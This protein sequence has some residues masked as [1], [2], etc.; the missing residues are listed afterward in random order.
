M[1]TFSRTDMSLLGQ[2]WQ[3]VDRWTIA[4][5]ITLATLGAF[6]IIAA[7]PPIAERLSLDTFHFVGRQ[8]LFLPLAM[9]S[10]FAVSFLSRANIRRISLI[11]FSFAA[12]LMIFTLFSGVEIKGATRWVNVVGVSLQPSEFIKPAF[13]VI[14][15]S[16][17]A[18]WRLEERFPG[19]LVVLGLYGG[20]VLLLIAQPDVGMAILI[21]FVWGLQF[22]LAGLPMVLVMGIGTVFFFGG[23]AAYFQFSHVRERIE[24]FIDPQNSDVYQVSQSL[25]AFK[26]GGVFGRG[27]GEGH[28]KENL[29]DAHSD[30]I[31]AVAVEEFGM[32]AGLLIVSVFGF[33]VLRGLMRVFKETDLFVQLAV[34]GLLAQF[35][36]Q[37]IINLAST[38]NLMPTKGATLPFVS[39]GG[40]SLLALSISMGMVLSLTRE[41][42]NSKFTSRTVWER[43]K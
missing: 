7:S 16:M 6:L 10:M 24:R 25:E 3:T 31:F 23:F 5:I 39:Y 14:A 33:I 32:I 42:P 36:L 27:P 9:I 28:V 18:A 12:A 17:F 26:K 41:R 34:T 13:A 19:Y 29:P 35:G 43:R 22:F 1:T 4:A 30:F 15:A 21:S 8:V 11:V 40:S 20:V 37:A 38:L 2:W